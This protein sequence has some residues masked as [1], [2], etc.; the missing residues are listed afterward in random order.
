MVHKYFDGVIPA[1]DFNAIEEFGINLEQE[2]KSACMEYE[3]SMSEFS[4][5]KAMIAVWGFISQMNKY[6]DVTAPWALEK[7]KEARKQLQIVLYHLLEG[8]RVVSGLIYPVMPETA[9]T[10]QQHL[11]LDPSEYCFDLEKLKA[12]NHLKPGIAL[13]KS[14]TLFPRIDVKKALAKGLPASDD[15][16]SIAAFKPEI[17]FEEFAKIDLRTATIIKAEPVPRSKKLLKLEIDVGEKRTIVAGIA[18]Q[19]AVDDLIGKQIILVANLK[20]AKIMGILSNGMLL[21]AS[22]KKSLAV[23]TFDQSTKPGTPLR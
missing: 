19:V 2:A 16:P 15:T 14:V 8:L 6:I 9:K 11:G 13:P 17:T 12:W 20:P 18:Q 4:F 10:M 21:A 5:H 1:I 3:K 22:D 23:A 7:R